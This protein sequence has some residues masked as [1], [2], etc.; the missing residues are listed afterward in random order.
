MG[1]YRIDIRGDDFRSGVVL[2]QGAD[3]VHRS[4]VQI[5][6][7]RG[8][9]LP[10][11]IVRGDDLLGRDARFRAFPLVCGLVLG[12]PEQQ[13]RLVAE[14]LH[15]AANARLIRGAALSCN[16]SQADP[17]AH[18]VGAGLFEI[19]RRGRDVNQVAAR[20]MRFA[21]GVGHLGQ[22]VQAQ[23]ERAR[24]GRRSRAHSASENATAFQHPGKREIRKKVST[25]HQ[26]INS[27]AAVISLAR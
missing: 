6:R 16:R 3:Q 17:R 5:E 4:V 20:F 13:G 8:I 22:V 15:D 18:L 21:P 1:D 23:Y 2:L 10:H 9:D 27:S 7:V 14:L 12:F 19:L 25:L 26:G 24:C 11:K